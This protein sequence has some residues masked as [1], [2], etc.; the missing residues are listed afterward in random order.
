MWLKG[1]ENIRKNKIN[2]ERVCTGGRFLFFFFFFYLLK[3]EEECV[4]ME[5]EE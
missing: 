2:K 1:L 3:K 5:D 4:H